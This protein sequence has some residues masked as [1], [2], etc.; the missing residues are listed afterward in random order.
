MA[1]P[2]Q[3]AFLHGTRWFPRRPTVIEF[4]DVNRFAMKITETSDTNWDGLLPAAES[5]FA[6]SA[7]KSEVM[8]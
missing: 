1:D 2:R 5:R 4:G 6:D 3:V 8:P 7:G